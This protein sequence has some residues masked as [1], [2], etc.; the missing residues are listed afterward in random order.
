[1]CLVE[2]RAHVALF[3]L[4]FDT[5]VEYRLADGG[6]I[7]LLGSLFFPQPKVISVLL[8]SLACFLFVEVATVLLK[9]FLSAVK[10]V[11]LFFGLFEKFLMRTTL[12]RIHL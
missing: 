9:L 8:G 10:G 12:S 11:F 6:P 2:I 5:F 3:V 1:M 4:N 7:R